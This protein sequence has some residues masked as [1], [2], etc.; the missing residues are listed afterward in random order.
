MSFVYLIRHG[1]AGTR[2]A[3]DTLSETGREQARRLGEYFLAQGIAFRAAIAGGLERQ[4]QTGA[5]VRRAYA[6]AGLPFPE[7]AT[8]PRWNEFDLDCV[9]RDMVPALRQADAKFDAAYAEIERQS[10]DASAAIHR[11]WTPC[12][13]EVIRAWIEGRVPCQGESWS[14]FHARV[15]SALEGIGNFAQDENLAVFT[16]AVPAGICA[17]STLGIQD[18]RSM[19]LAGVL[20]N[21]SY[22]ILRVRDGEAILLSL[23]NVPHLP[24]ALRTYR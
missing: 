19:R 7:I 22:S 11:R 3:Y 17:A 23:N 12:D 9:Y 21:A 1:Q 20:L 5:E 24:A 18:Y 14:E 4:A 8:D 6:A 16:S 13:V 15:L 10:P 2:L